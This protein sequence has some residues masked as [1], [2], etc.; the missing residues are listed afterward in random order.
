MF[1]ITPAMQASWAADDEPKATS[2]DIALT[3]STLGIQLPDD[4]K[5]FVSRYGF[6]MFGR[7]SEERNLF[8][9]VIDDGGQAVTRQRGVSFLFDLDKVVRNYRYMI[10]EEDPEDDSRPMIPT[11]YLPVASDAGH[12]RILLDIAAHPGQVWF[13]PES[14]WRWGREDNRALGFV[15]ESFEAFINGLRP[16]PL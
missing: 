4:Y 2:A 6:V 13:W 5:A 8:T 7:D 10:S 15:A 3:E 16:Y 11:G 12:G 1:Q 14:E 9:Y